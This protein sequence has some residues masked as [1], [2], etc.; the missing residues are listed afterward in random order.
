MDNFVIAH[1]QSQEVRP[2]EFVIK[3]LRQPLRGG[4]VRFW[5]DLVMRLCCA[6]AFHNKVYLIFMHCLLQENAE[7]IRRYLLMIRRY[8]DVII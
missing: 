5:S 7:R 2:D 3:H 6:P 1:P 8:D 4:L